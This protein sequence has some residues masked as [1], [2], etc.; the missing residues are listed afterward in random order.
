MTASVRIT[1]RVNAVSRTASRGESA[2]PRTSPF[3]L[4]APRPTTAAV[5]VATASGIAVT[6]TVAIDI[7]RPG[8]MLSAAVLASVTAIS[9][10]LAQPSPAEVEASKKA[11]VQAA[12]D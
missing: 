7:M 9:P 4:G 1:G 5:A 2:A 3:S 11:A 12:N 6:L 10:A 8:T